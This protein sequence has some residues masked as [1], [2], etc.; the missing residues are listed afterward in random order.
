MDSE[1]LA[2][3]SWFVILTWIAKNYKLLGADDF[4]M[5]CEDVSVF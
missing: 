4:H 1:D 3:F 2:I 5:D